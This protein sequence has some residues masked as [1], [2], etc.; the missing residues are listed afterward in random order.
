METNIVPSIEG[1]M[2][3]VLLQIENKLED[4]DQALSEKLQSEEE[5]YESMFEYY[6]DSMNW[7]QLFHNKI[8]DVAK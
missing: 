5:R 6:K 7:L 8:Q 4:V 1:C 2:K 3:K